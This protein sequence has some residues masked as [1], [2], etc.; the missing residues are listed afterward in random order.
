DLNAA[1]LEDV[2]DFFRTYYAPNNASLAIVGD[3][4]PAQTKAWIERYFGGIPAGPPIERP[5]PMPVVLEAEKRLVLED[6]VQLPRLYLTWPSPALYAEGDADLEV[7]GDVLAGGRSSR[8][9][10]RL[11]YEE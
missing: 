5:R 9:Y 1:S 3:F 7:V 8:L 2:T 11:V 4:E 6:R 10:Q